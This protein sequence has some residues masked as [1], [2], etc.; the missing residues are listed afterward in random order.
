M[1]SFK[2]NKSESFELVSQNCDDFSSVLTTLFE[3][4][5]K[6]GHNSQADFIKELILLINQENFNSFIQSL[7][8]V[9]MWGGAGAVWEVY[10]EDKESSKE[11]E[12]S[13]IKLINIMEETKILG[14]GIKPIRKL[15][16]KNL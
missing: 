16:E 6:N 9:N 10:I 12:K 13:V 5:K 3:L 4:L 8:G 11:F 14:K 15:F 1:F 7:N 2:K